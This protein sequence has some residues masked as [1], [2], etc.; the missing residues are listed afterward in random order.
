MLF[1]NLAALPTQEVQ[2]IVCALAQLGR[3]GV[4]LSRSSS[5]CVCTGG[6]VNLDLEIDSAFCRSRNIPI[7]QRE[8]RA[9]MICFAQKQI[10]LQMV[11]P[12]H[13]RFL[14]PLAA[15]NC[16]KILTPFWNV[17]RDLGLDVEY[18]SPNE[19]LVAGRRI[20]SACAGETHQH[21]L[22]A[23]GM[24]LEFDA[25]LFA[26][27]LNV[28]DENLRTRI[29]ELAR[30]HR[31]SLFEELGKLPPA[32]T[33]ERQ[34]REHLQHIAGGLPPSE[35]DPALRAQMRD[36]VAAMSSSMRPQHREIRASGWRVD[37]GAGA[38]LRECAYQAPGGF[39]HALCEWRDERIVTASLSGDFFCYPPGAL[40][41]LEQALV[42]TRADQLDVKLAEF[43]RKLGLVTPGIRIGHWAKV[44]S[45]N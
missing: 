17:C 16:R 32:Q 33:L 15:D 19:L 41:Q 42:G 27:V 38:E 8:T 4:V 37:L 29:V 12:R 21:V 45:P 20:A 6:Q 25:E 1:Y 35:L 40:F 9:A 39:L 13:H 2:A 22:L 10:E 3:E 7:F 5:P 34:L 28:Q 44:L 26:G 31:T 11:V 18:K 24:A 14:T 30:R 43:Y 36:G 23:A